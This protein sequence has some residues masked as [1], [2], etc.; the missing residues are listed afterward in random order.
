M[1]LSSL[2]PERTVIDPT[3]FI[4]Q[5]AVVL[6]D[7]HIGSDASIWFNAVVRGDMAAIRIGART[8][9]QDGTVL[10]VDDD[11]PLHIGQGVTI[12][13]LCIVHG[14]TIG[15]RSLIGMGSIVMNGVEL[16]EDCLVGA[17]SLLTENKVFPPRSVIVGRPA[18][19]VRTLGDADLPKL[20]HGT[21]HYVE[22]GRAYRRRGLDARER[23]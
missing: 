10:H 13:H 14:C 8:N 7:V 15:D 22:A 6:G 19:V 21:E 4:A 1:D 17:G 18:R 2:D 16:G 20:R 9:V 3:A 23:S 11:R 5:G 12:G